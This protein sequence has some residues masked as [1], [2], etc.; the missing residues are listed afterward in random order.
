MTEMTTD[1]I[2]EVLHD[3]AKVGLRYHRL[4]HRPPEKVWP[5]LTESPSLRHWFPTDIV[6]ERAA[7][8][9]LTLPFWPESSEEG[10][11]AV[12][13]RGVDP[14][15]MVSA[16]ELLAWEPPR[17]FELTWSVGERAD[18]ADLLRFELERSGDGTLL[19][20]TTWL[21][22]QA[23][24]DAT[25]TKRAAGTATGWHVCLDELERLADRGPM[26]PSDQAAAIVVQRV[27]ARMAELSERYTALLSTA[28]S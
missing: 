15:D 5:V 24:T 21:G 10:G 25:E 6:G 13:D 23:P 4:L 11:K 8:A 19:H 1:R 9:S 12:D 17:V 2:G 20:F 3:G 16:G 14:E 18:L 26:S 7:G 27:K 28:S 22:G